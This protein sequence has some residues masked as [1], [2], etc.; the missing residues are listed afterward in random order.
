MIAASGATVVSTIP[1]AISDAV[2]LIP[3]LREAEGGEPIRKALQIA[4]TKDSSSSLA[5][6]LDLPPPPS[7][8]VLS[9]LLDELT[10]VRRR[11][12]D[13]IQ[14]YD[15]IICPVSPWTAR[16]HGFDPGQDR[17]KSW[18]HSMAYNVTGWPGVTVPA[19]MDGDGLPIGVQVVAKPW[20]E[21]VALALAAQIEKSLGGFAP[22]TGT[23]L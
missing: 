23:G 14:Q 4:G 13:F 18:S 15:A 10:D 11:M 8:N 19:G 3:S 6:A 2:A 12:L 17:Y 22:P 20:R 16:P 5:Y 21:D 9:S 1:E 7:G